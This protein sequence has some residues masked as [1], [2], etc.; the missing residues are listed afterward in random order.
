MLDIA[1]VSR[2]SGIPASALRYYEQQGLIVSR[3]RVNGYR[4]F[5]PETIETVRRIKAL[6][7]LGLTL[8]TIRELLPC[9]EGSTGDCNALSAK[10]AELRD[11]HARQAAALER[12]SRAIEGYLVANFARA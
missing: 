11:S 12:A 4:D 8:E 5:G 9:E 6:L 3:R 1:E 7:A 2:R 10:L